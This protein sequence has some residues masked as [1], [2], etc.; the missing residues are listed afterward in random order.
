MDQRRAFQNARPQRIVQS[1]QRQRLDQRLD[2]GGK[3]LV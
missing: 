3:A 2:N 1:R